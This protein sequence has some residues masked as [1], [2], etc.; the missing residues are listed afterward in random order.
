M[1]S[2]GALAGSGPFSAAQTLSRTCPRHWEARSLESPALEPLALQ[3]LAVV[4][5]LPFQP[6]SAADRREPTP[7]TVHVQPQGALSTLACELQRDRGTASYCSLHCGWL[8]PSDGQGN[9]LRH[10]EDGVVHSDPCVDDLED[11]HHRVPA[12]WAPAGME[13]D[14]YLRPPANEWAACVVEHD[15]HLKPPANEWAAH[16]A[17]PRRLQKRPLDAPDALDP[18]AATP[19]RRRT[20]RS[21]YFLR[22][23]SASYALTAA[24]SSVQ[25][26]LLLPSPPS[27]F[28]GRFESQ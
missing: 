7:R 13:H 17:L 21:Y 3:S 4:R 11:A 27:T 14:C 10:L 20:C 19:S 2:V 6:R 28:R 8:Q 5:S 23:Q 1:R 22:Q 15:R 26:E 16:V 24:L 12:G 9:T 18:A 25:G